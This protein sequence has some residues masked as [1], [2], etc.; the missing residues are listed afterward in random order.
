MA[1][2]QV[3]WVR[4]R[5]RI[6]VSAYIFN[7][8]CLLEVYAVATDASAHVRMHLGG[9]YDTAHV[10]SGEL[11]LLCGHNHVKRVFFANILRISLAYVLLRK[12]QLR[13]R[14]PAIPEWR[15]WRALLA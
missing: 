3:L 14:T 5:V 9:P 4:A 8:M 1:L 11:K 12:H 2:F 13:V 15:R 6:P 10:A 7:H